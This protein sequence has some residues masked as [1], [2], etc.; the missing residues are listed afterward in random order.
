MQRRTNKAGGLVLLFVL[1]A[2]IMPAAGLAGESNRVKAREVRVK[3][4][5]AQGMAAHRKGDI[6]TAAARWR[7]VLMIDPGNARASLYLK[8]IGPE[9]E[10]AAAARQ[11]RKQQIDAEA[12]G[13]RKMAEK[14][15][16]EVKE[17]TG[18]REFVQTLSFISGINF[19]LVGGADAP[20]VAKFEDK[21]LKE[22]LDAVLEPNGLAWSRKGDVVT[23]APRLATRVFRLG[24]EDLVKVQR[25]Y[26]SGQLQKLLWNT[27]KPPIPGIQLT[28]DERLS[29]L[30]LTDSPQNIE[31]TAQLLTELRQQTLPRLATR[32]Y[33]IRPDLADR[34]KVLVEALLQT[35]AEPPYAMVRRALVAQHPNGTDLVIRDTEENVR[36]VESLLTDRQFMQHLEKKEIEVYTTNLTPRDVFSANREQVAEFGRNVVEVVETMLYHK[37]GVAAAR[38]EG[39]RLWYDPA[40]MQLT[41]ADYPSNIQ[42]VAAFIEALPQLEPKPRSKIIF[43]EHA[44]AGDLASLLE[45]VMGISAGTTAAAGAAAG[46]E[47][48]FSLRVQDERTFRDLS[49]R[50]VR[51]DENNFQDENDDSCQ[52]VVRTSRAQSSDLSIPEFRSEVFEDY[53]IYVER[54][55]P[56]PQIGEG[57]VRLR[58]RYLGTNGQA[59]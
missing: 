24:N 27:D 21:P 9:L 44:V 36:K 50:L 25:L 1:A 35:G 2:G 12:E 33:S 6:E 20:V 55:Y 15:T 11:A 56:S 37:T 32:I 13:A 45:Q 38:E 5:L 23:I 46:T 47:A 29:V 22:I 4:L 53:E 43:L 28:L 31:K 54:V 26:E 51:V 3:E 10:K 8:E 30:T 14:I 19:V 17:G 58:V 42:K 52:L 48:A 34:V 40:T 57:R 41:V 59:Y 39:R 18:L 49:V 16:I 7:E